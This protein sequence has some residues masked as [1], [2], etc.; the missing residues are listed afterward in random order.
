M[1]DDHFFSLI[2][3]HNERVKRKKERKKNNN[4]IE[5]IIDHDA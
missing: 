5:D 4:K 2:I 1:I 3:G